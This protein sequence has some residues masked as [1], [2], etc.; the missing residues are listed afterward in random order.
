MR[1]LGHWLAAHPAEAVALAWIVSSALYSLLPPRLARSPV[2]RLLGRVSVVT[3]R[4]AAGSLKLPGA[5]PPDVPHVVAE[6]ARE[7]V[8]PPLPADVRAP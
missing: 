1:A 2:G 6:T 5:A 4:L 3:H 8:T 7:T